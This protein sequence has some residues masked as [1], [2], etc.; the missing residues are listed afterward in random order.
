MLTAPTRR[1]PWVLTLLAKVR[2]RL[3]AEY[4]TSGKAER[5]SQLEQFLPGEES[6]LTYAEAAA[7]LG[8]AEGTLKSDVHRLKRRYGELAREEIAHT[9]GK[10]EDVEDEWR[11]LIEVASLRR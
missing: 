11:H 5:F 8:V 3:A 7:S 6:S 1:L 4:A 10:P 2:E 9:V